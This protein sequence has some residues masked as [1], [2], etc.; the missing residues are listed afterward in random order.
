MIITFTHYK[1]GTGKTTSCLNTAGF[2][3]KKGYKVLVIDLDPQANATTGLGIDKETIKK[4]MYHVMNR[5]AELKQIIIAGPIDNLHIAPTKQELELAKIISYKKKSDA[6]ILKNAIE[7]VEQ[8]Y[9]FVLI[10]TPPVHAH[11]IINGLAAADKVILILDPGVFSLEGIETLQNAFGNFFNKIGLKLNID[12]A[13]VTKSR[14]FTLFRK[15]PAKEIQQEAEILLGRPT[16][17]IPYSDLIYDTHLWG[18]PLSH[19]KP[20]SKIA[21]AYEKFANSI[22]EEY[23]TKKQVEKELGLGEN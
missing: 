5:K 8:Y 21:K 22:I 19:L 9:D 7:K 23:E 2:L 1:G 11:F 13:L 18:I 10:D 16:Y 3:A 6:E 20:N 12:A 14:G 15:N 4:N 17:L